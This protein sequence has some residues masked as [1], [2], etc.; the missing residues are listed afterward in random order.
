MSHHLYRHFDADSV[1]LYVGRSRCA[2][3]RLSGHKRESTWYDAI[4]CM[5]IE[6]FA[7]L[8][9]VLRAEQE[10]IRREK[11]RFN[12]Q[13]A[14]PEA[15]SP[16]KGW[17]SKRPIDYSLGIAREPERASITDV[18]TGKWRHLQ[19]RGLAPMPIGL[20]PNTVGWLRFGLYQW[21]A[22]RAAER[23]QP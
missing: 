13:G 15:P 6:R 23:V 3:G 19:S 18:P 20:T 4:A 22:E 11:P 14:M 1:L 2:L 5:T 21:A 9:Q 12:V 8:Q 10:A 16:K 17:R 7:T